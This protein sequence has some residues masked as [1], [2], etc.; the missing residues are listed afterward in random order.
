M[1]EQ[2]RTQRALAH[3]NLD[4]HAR[5]F[6]VRDAAEYRD[7][8]RLIHKVAH[9]GYV[10]AK[11][12]EAIARR[13]P[14]MPVEEWNRGGVWANGA[15]TAHER[16]LRVST[17][18]AWCISRANGGVPVDPHYV[19]EKGVREGAAL[20]VQDFAAPLTERLEQR[21]AHIDKQNGINE[22]S[23]A[24]E[25]KRA[26]MQ[27]PERIRHSDVEREWNRHEGPQPMLNARE[28]AELIAQRIE[29]NMDEARAAKVRD[30][31]P[32]RRPDRGDDRNDDTRRAWNAVALEEMGL[33]AIALRENHLE[34]VDDELTQ[35]ARERETP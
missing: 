32:G 17:V 7:H 2:S 12:V 35:A 16:A 31:D 8:L 1:S 23:R 10:S 3:K 34:S 26:A 27:N 28:K 21:D 6:G 19:L 25:A 29:G 30:S 24:E 15:A 4:V 22:R 9:G 14:F 20:A 33:D 18:V 11:D 5:D 13:N